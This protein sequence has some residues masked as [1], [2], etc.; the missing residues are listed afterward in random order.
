M[1]WPL[2][3]AVLGFGMTF[4]FVSYFYQKS[5]STLNKT[6]T[7]LVTS[8]AFTLISVFLLFVMFYVDI[9]SIQSHT[10]KGPIN[11]P[12]TVLTIVNVVFYIV[13]PFLYFYFQNTSNSNSTQEGI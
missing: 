6:S 9:S 8:L 13:I 3:L 5:F 12:S 1:L 4:A 10:F 2:S 7:I 11:F